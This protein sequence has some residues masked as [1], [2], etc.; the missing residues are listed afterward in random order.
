MENEIISLDKKLFEKHMEIKK[1]ELEL[2]ELESEY[3]EFL[4]RIKKIRAEIAEK[5]EEISQL[6]EELQNIYGDAE[7]PILGVHH[8]FRFDEDFIVKEFKEVPEDFKIPDDSKIRKGIKS[9][10][11]IPGI[12]VVK[13]RIIVIRWGEEYDRQKNKRSKRK[14]K[15]TLSELRR[16]GFIVRINYLCCGNCAGFSIA[17]TVEKLDKKKRSKIKGAIFWTKQDDEKFFQTGELF[18]YYGDIDTTKHG[19]IGIKTEEV[20]KLV[21][22]KLTEKGL[23]VFWNGDPS[24]RIK[25]TINDLSK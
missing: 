8:T 16:Q 2:K 23:K 19:L 11:I 13:R 7:K 6:K 24:T 3:S 20:G 17:S 22:E 1:K 18:I 25:V 5:K 14:I 12:I 21:V 10:I 9:G 15:E 4:N